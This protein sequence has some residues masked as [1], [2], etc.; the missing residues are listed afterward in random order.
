MHRQPRSRI[1]RSGIAALVMWCAAFDAL[2]Q[3]P[4]QVDSGPANPPAAQ[5]LERLSATRDRPLFSPTR[6][7]VPPPPPPVEHVAA[8]PPP[9]PPPKVQLYGIVVDGEAARAI[10]RSG[11]DNVDRVQIGD[12]IGGWTVSQIEGRLLVLSLG[13]RLA[14]F[15]LFS[16]EGGKSS[17]GSTGGPVEKLTDQSSQKLIDR[18]SQSTAPQATE[19][20]PR[21]RRRSRQ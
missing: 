9:P 10:V 21:R 11:T 4:E 12:N 13:D 2:A 1:A 8:P 14:K 6:R 20:Q 16:D 17:P 7:P 15:T 3:T 5:S 19:P 18:S